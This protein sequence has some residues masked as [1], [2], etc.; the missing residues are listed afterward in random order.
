MQ[1]AYR[2]QLPGV[3]HPV[4]TA[5]EG[6]TIQLY[7]VPPAFLATVPLL[8]PAPPGTPVHQLAAHA[9]AHNPA[10][11]GLPYAPRIHKAQDDVG[12]DPLPGRR[13]HVFRDARDAAAQ[14]MV[15]NL[16]SPKAAL[17]RHA[18]SARGEFQERHYMTDAAHDQFPCPHTLSKALPGLQ[19]YR[20]TQDGRTVP[21]VHTGILQV[22]GHVIVI[23][24]DR[25]ILAF[26]CISSHVQCCFRV[27][28][29][30]LHYY[31]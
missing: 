21:Y 9:N 30:K 20:V 26:H 18:A 22:C 31:C 1:D 4:Q 15:S 14:Q 27:C 10:V 19:A 12:H 24:I 8:P 13:T 11:V 5:D 2:N 25:T 16:I 23:E 29:T 28:N 17:A 3:I 7:P 6:V